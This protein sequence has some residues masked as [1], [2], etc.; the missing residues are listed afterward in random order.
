[1]PRILTSESCQAGCGE[2]ESAVNQVISR[3]FVKKQQM[4]CQTATAYL[5][6]QVRTRT[7]N[8]TLRETSKR[9]WPA[10]TQVSVPALS[11]SQPTKRDIK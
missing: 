1:M 8:G 11:L 7:L 4:R 6:L 9:W 10:M 3:R 2:A 5:M